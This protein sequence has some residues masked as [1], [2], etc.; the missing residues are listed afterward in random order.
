MQISSISYMRLI[1][2]IAVFLLV[3][4]ASSPVCALD[5][6]RAASQ[7]SYRQWRINDTLPQNSVRAITQDSNGLLW[8]STQAGLRWFDGVTFG[9]LPDQPEVLSSFHVYALAADSKG[10]LWIGTNGGGLLHLLNGTYRHY[11]PAD[12]LSL[13]ELSGIHQRRQ[14]LHF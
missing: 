1:Q 3:G 5:P 4:M 2:T 14:D 12:G 6:S 10:G 9:S 11:S 7:H 8:L 13:S